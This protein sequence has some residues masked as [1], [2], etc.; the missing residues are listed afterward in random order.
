[1]DEKS[2]VCIKEFG[3]AVASKDYVALVRD[4][5][6]LTFY[7]VF[8]KNGVDGEL[9]ALVDVHDHLAFLAGPDRGAVEAELADFQIAAGNGSISIKPVTLKELARNAA[10]LG[11]WI[12]WAGSNGGVVVDSILRILGLAAIARNESGVECLYRAEILE[13][14]ANEQMGTGPV[15]AQRWTI[16]SIV[17]GQEGD[18]AETRLVYRDDGVILLNPDGGLLN[19]PRARSTL[20]SD[21]QVLF[22]EW[23]QQLYPLPS[24]DVPDVRDSFDVPVRSNVSDIPGQ[25]GQASKELS[26]EETPLVASAFREPGATTPANQAAVA[27]LDVNTEADQ[28]FGRFIVLAFAITIVGLVVLANVQ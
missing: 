8:A 11:A 23:N 16:T 20:T 15:T 3:K 28:R 10:M 25:S 24:P 9:P 17:D 14:P 13:L 1:M 7:A 21:E 27:T 6:E 4:W 22:D 5:Q 12:V 19:G 2:T 18:H 26:Q